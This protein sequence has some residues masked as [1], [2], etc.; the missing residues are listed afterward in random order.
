MPR[1]KP[2]GRKGS[3]SKA[4]K[5]AATK[6]KEEKA[7]QDDDVTT[8]PSEND[9]EIG[10]SSAH[11]RR[12]TAR[13]SKRVVEENEEDQMQ[14]DNVEAEE[15]AQ[16]ASQPGYVKLDPPAVQPPSAS[17]PIPTPTPIPSRS[18]AQPS[19]E[20]PSAP[21]VPTDE[22]DKLTKSACTYAW[23][24]YKQPLARAT[25]NSHV[26]R[27]KALKRKL[28]AGRLPAGKDPN[29]P[30]RKKYWLEAPRGYLAMGGCEKVVV[31]TGDDL[32]T[33]VYKWYNHRMEVDAKE[34]EGPAVNGKE[35]MKKSAK[36]Q[37]EVERARQVDEDTLKTERNYVSNDAVLQT[38]YGFTIYSSLERTL[39]SPARAFQSG[40]S[41]TRPK[42]GRLSSR[43]RERGSHQVVGRLL[44]TEV[45]G[46]RRQLALRGI[47]DQRPVEGAKRRRLTEQS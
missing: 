30:G 40:V 41:W 32:N 35:K 26:E 5:K 43:L 22:V 38:R 8:L 46:Y 28:A 16:A 25:L 23:P 19:H 14:I 39:L 45:V 10:E 44:R 3:S 9:E 42:G 37:K 17:A 6:S 33:A 29:P 18:L 20:L 1:A 7:P 36:E 11:P 31:W 2:S 15:S 21:A 24:I 4:P 13:K 27:E 12:A 34:G 47:P